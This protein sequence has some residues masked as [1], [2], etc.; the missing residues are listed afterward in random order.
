MD[1]AS[2]TQALVKVRVRINKTVCMWM[3]SP[4]IGLM[5]NG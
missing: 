2:P 5:V 1:F 4:I 3:I